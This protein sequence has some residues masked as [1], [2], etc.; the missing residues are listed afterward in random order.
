MQKNMGCES[1]LLN[2]RWAAHDAVK[3]FETLREEAQE[4]IILQKKTVIPH[5]F[6]NRLILPSVRRPSLMSALGHARLRL[7]ACAAAVHGFRLSKG[8]Y[9]ATL[10]EAGVS[11]LN[12]DPFTG[13]KF[14]YRTSEQGF[15]VYSS[16]PDGKDDGG[17]RATDNDPDH[18]DIS[19][20]SSGLFVNPPSGAIVPEDPLWLK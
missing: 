9:P 14:V 18:G 7:T 3:Y 6:L 15:L 19:L 5:H 10:T 1:R 4:V 2:L 8:R 20:L 16:G 13:G 12:S 17:R 11:D